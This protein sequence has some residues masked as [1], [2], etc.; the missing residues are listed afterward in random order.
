[1]ALFQ[2]G[3][4]KITIQ[5][6]SLGAELKSLKR[7]PDN[8]EYMWHGDPAYWGRTSPVLFP[9]VG[10]LQD[11][12]YRA[13]GREYRMGQ[14]GFAR[15]REFQLKSRAASEIRFSLA[16]DADTLQK[17]PYPFFLE[18]GYELVERAVVVKWRVSSQAAEPVWF[19]IGGHPAFLCPIDPGTD[20]T[21]YKLLFDTKEHIVASCI[22][23]GLLS[24]EKK[25]YALRDGVLPVTADLFDQDALVI[26]NDQAHSVA[27]VR[28]DGSPYLTVD[29]DAPLFGIWSPPKKKAPFICIEPW[30]G[31]CDRAGFAGEWK[32]REWMQC[33]AG[34]AFEASYRITIA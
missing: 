9:L 15:D 5:V 12:K 20:Q 33:L 27:L 10:G 30:Y 1:M 25:T 19:S 21:Q 31:R 34:K 29:F 23:G 16:S 14:H 13:E 4:D 24:G 18:I 3:N 7:L 32:E 2:I 17:Y 6:D 8:W 28:P 11:G 22:E 26:E